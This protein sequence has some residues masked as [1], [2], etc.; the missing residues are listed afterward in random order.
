MECSSD[1]EY[2]ARAYTSSLFLSDMTSSN[3]QWKLKNQCI[4]VPPH[5]PLPYLMKS[6][7][8]LL[9]DVGAFI[10]SSASKHGGNIGYVMRIGMEGSSSWK[11][12]G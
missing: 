6:V 2:R 3:A 5:I 12:K 8:E 11:A 7:R 9:E 1:F 10:K 4:K